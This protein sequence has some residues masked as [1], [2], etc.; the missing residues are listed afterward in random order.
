VKVKLYTSD[1]LLGNI[2][3]SRGRRCGYRTLLIVT[4]T[5]GDRSCALTLLGISADSVPNS[6]FIW[7][8][9]QI[10]VCPITALPGRYSGPREPIPS[11]RHYLAPRTPGYLPMKIP[12]HRNA[13]REER[14]N[15]CR[16]AQRCAGLTPHGVNGGDRASFA[17]SWYVIGVL[18]CMIIH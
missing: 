3:Q 8:R 16:A 13:E 4:G 9:G 18:R 5:G 14:D 15:A 1:C 6:C 2:A 7:R 17:A 12:G 10:A 11:A